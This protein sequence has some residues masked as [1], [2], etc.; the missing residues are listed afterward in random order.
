MVAHR[1]VDGGG[2][3]E[4][5]RGDVDFSWVVVKARDC[6]DIE[7]SWALVEEGGDLE[8]PEAVS[9]KARATTKE[10]NIPGNIS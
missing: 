9:L 1:R 8:R 5:L 2:W 7:T 3:L 10:Y 4:V 6:R